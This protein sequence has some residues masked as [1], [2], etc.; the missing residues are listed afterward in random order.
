MDRTEQRFRALPQDRIGIARRHRGRRTRCI[1][2]VKSLGVTF[3]DY[4]HDGDLDLYVTQPS[5]KQEPES[6]DGYVR[7]VVIVAEPGPDLLN[8]LWRN[9]GDGTFT[10]VTDATGL[11]GLISQY[12]CGRY[13]LQ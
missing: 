5:R 3:I 6:N 10:D 7:P 12:C 9:N 13:R 2:A 8:V 4:D 1:Y 11:D